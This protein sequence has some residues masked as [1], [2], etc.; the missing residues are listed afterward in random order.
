VKRIWHGLELPEELGF[1]LY[2]KN[3]CISRI[4][5]DKF[6]ESGARIQELGAKLHWRG[7]NIGN[8]S[9]SIHR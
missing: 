5:M 8:T 3:R 7:Q 2:I 9:G 6:G 1:A 4:S